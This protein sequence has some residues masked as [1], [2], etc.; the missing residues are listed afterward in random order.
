[1]SIIVDSHLHLYPCHDAGCFFEGLTQRLR[2]LVPRAQLAGVLTERG[3]DQ[4]FTGLRNGDFRVAGAKVCHMAE[5]G[6]LRIQV[7]DRDLILFA[8]RQVV[9]AERLEVAALLTTTVFEDGHPAHDVMAEIRDAGA[10]PVLPWGVGK[11]FFRRGA[12]VR[13]MVEAARPG[14]LLVGDSAMRP[15]GWPEPGSIRMARRCGLG[16]LAG[17]DP[18]PI[19]GDE[20]LAGSYAS[21]LDGVIDEERPVSSFRELLVSAGLRTELVGRRSGPWPVLLRILRLRRACVCRA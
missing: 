12:M 11:W 9:T 3:Q 4:V 19:P 5:P 7:A 2:T 8:G 1:M 17:S 18:L 16:V 15:L 14:T 20:M 10:V 13:A 21:R 6:A